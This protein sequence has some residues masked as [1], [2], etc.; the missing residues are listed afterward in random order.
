MQE[1]HSKFG[2]MKNFV[3]RHRVTETE[4]KRA[5]KNEKQAETLRIRSS[6][7]FAYL[8]KMLL[9]FG[10]TCDKAAGRKRAAIKE[11]VG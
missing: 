9:H 3:A 5:Y 2:W 1:R 7:V 8:E 6:S 10:I 11:A 4:S